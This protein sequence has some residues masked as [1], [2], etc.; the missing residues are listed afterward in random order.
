MNPNPRPRA[1]LRMTVVAMA[2]MSV[3]AVA[4]SR[5]SRDKVPEVFKDYEAIEVKDGGTIAGTI[6]YEGEVPAP[7]KIAIV[8]DA[9]VCRVHAPERQRIKV[10][11]K[12][13]LAE[14]VV[15]LNLKKG[16]KVEEPKEKPTVDQ[17]GCEFVPHVQV[18][19]VDAP[20]L[21]RNSD[22][23]LHN[24]QAAQKM[25]TLFNHVQAT[26]GQERDEVFKEPGLVVIQCQAHTWMEGWIYVLPHP[27]HAVTDEKGAFKITDV[28]PGV[29]EL[30]V[31][32]EHLGEQVF[33]VKVEAGK[34]TTSDQKMEAKSSRRR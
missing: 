13:Q 18:V 6:T 10:N 16:R 12:K 4:Q 7:D 25:R 20:V 17:K 11:D 32:Q 9:E 24:I 23:V 15:F 3:A 14:A 31:W 27:Y 26:K 19:H 28:P 33:Q 8:K 22:T 29:Y 34:T 21:I 30:H 5:R 2:L 1:W